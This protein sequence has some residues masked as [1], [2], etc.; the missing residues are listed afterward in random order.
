[1]TESQKQQITEM[2]RQGKKY[3]EI[4]DSL[5]I[6]VGT[7]KAFCSRSHTKPSA[8]SM[9]VTSVSHEKERCKRCGQPLVNSPG[10]RQKTFC[11]A[12][13]RRKYW[14]ENTE[15]MR[16]PSFVT[17]TCPACGKVFSDYAGHRRKYCSHAC[18]IASRYRKADAHESE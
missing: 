16:H 2:R 18:Y 12:A 5:T 1:M 10:H 4:S 15:L 11:S 9:A 7:I 14:Q 13:C 3:A 6:P 17:I 8:A